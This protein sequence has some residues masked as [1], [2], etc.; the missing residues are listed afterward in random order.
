MNESDRGQVSR[1]AAQVYEEFFVPALFAQWPRRVAAAAG[2]G[3]GQRVLD[4]A[5]GTGI[6]ARTAA[7]MTGPTGSVVGLDVNDGMLAEASRMALPVEWRH[8][9]AES[10]PFANESFDAVVSQFGLMFFE[11]KIAALQEMARVLRPQGRMAVAVWAGLEDSPGYA[12]LVDLLQSQIGAEA[13]NSLRGPFSLGDRSALVD[14]FH[15]A[16]LSDAQVATYPGTARF[17][18]VQDWVFTEIRGWT[19][20]DS[21]DDAQYARLSKA[22]GRALQPF[23]S[24]GGT[25]AFSIPAHIVTAQIDGRR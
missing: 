25:V 22:A 2:I 9:R 24:A 15:E 17:P 14:L 13:A 5:C 10:L 6:L 3:P 16:G 23:V 7:E 11:D 8:G 1:S 12:T 4:V 20:A 18:S 19:L 21:I